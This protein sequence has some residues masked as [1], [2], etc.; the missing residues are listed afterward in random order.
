MGANLD[1]SRLDSPVQTLIASCETDVSD[2]THPKHKLHGMLEIFFPHEIRPPKTHVEA[3]FTDLQLLL[4]CGS[5]SLKATIRL[6][7][8]QAV[9][10]SL[11]AFLGVP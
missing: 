8:V 4:S 9:E 2:T 1:A 10:A 7:S 3:S 5:E 11:G 6:G